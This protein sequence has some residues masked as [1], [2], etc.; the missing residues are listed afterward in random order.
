MPLNDFN[1]A[2]ITEHHFWLQS[3]GNHAHLI[4]DAL[5]ANEKKS[6]ENCEYFINLFDT[7]LK[8]SHENL[9]SEEL[10]ELTNTALKSSQDFLTFKI[11]ILSSMLTSNMR[12]NLSP[13]H[14]NHMI[15]EIE[16]YIKILG[17]INTNKIPVF[18]VSHYNLL[19][20]LDCSGHASLIYSLLDPTERLYI[21]TCKRFEEDFI[22]LYIKSLEIKGFMRINENEFPAYNKLIKDSE[23]SILS[24]QNLLCE[25][26]QLSIEKKLLGQITPLILDHMYRES[27][28]YLLKL[29]KIT[30][31]KKPECDP[32]KPRIA[33]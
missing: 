6:I 19:W 2:V 15:N 13:S 31:V 14:I 9:S 11:V 7:L 27:C 33:N 5:L 16:E 12:I 21:K 18:T 29:S 24:F 10:S 3:L 17:I 26:E 1:R 32:G 8:K 28:Y 23:M 30:N 22:N 4:L 25:L 20:I